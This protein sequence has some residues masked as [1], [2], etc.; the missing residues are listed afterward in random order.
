MVKRLV[1]RFLETVA[2]QRYRSFM[3]RRANRH[4]QWMM[5]QY[6]VQFILDAFIKQ[7]GNKVMSGPF[8]GMIYITRSAGSSLLPKLIGSYEC[9]LHNVIDRIIKTS[10]D[11]VV[12]V[13]SAEGYY[14]V[15]LAIYLPGHPRVYAFDVDPEARRM[16]RELAEN[17]GV[18]DRV[19]IEDFCDA[20][21]LQ[22]SIGK[23]SLVVC[24]CEGFEIELLD[25]AQAPALRTTDILVELHEF[26]RPG[27]TSTLIER[28]KVTHDIQLIDTEGRKPADY[29]AVQFL[30]EEDQVVAL[31]EFRGGP[32]Q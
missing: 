7:H 31:S 9:E 5:N 26:L 13:G 18:S 25:Q 2:P 3:S 6:G 15:G 20:T 12:D 22:R 17:N 19:V 21:R 1:K 10:Y 16:C 8:A 4:G 14:A 11:T 32:M 23:R 27:A 29:P 30:S 28:F 24:D